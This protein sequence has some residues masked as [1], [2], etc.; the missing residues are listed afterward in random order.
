[1]ALDRTY[2]NVLDPGIGSCWR[3]YDGIAIGVG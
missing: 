2:A 1:V 3:A